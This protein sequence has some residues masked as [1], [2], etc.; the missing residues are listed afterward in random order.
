MNIAAAG[1]ATTGA[2]PVAF[3]AVF[4]LHA[5]GRDS[6]AIWRRDAVHPL[7]T[8]A[9]LH[10]G[11]SQLVGAL[12]QAVGEVLEV[13][14]VAGDAE[15]GV[16]LVVVGGQVGVGDRPVLAETVVRLPLE[17]VVRQSQREA[18]PDVGLAAE[19]SRAH[20]GVLGAGVGVILLVHQDVL[21]VI[22][23]AQ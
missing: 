22:L 4:V 2:A 9:Q 6:G 11:R 5:V 10:L 14:F 8:L 15:V 13:L 21:D 18:A 3:A 1:T 16:D 20:P 17:V 19:Q 23:A 7:E 12:K